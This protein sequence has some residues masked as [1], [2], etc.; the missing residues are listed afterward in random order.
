MLALTKNSSQIED[1]YFHKL[2]PNQEY[3]LQL[4]L[5]SLY[6]LINDAPSKEK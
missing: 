4:K 5:V 6:T 3:T 2:K 1:N